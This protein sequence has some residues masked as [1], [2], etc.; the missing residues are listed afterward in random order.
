MPAALVLPAIRNSISVIYPCNQPVTCEVANTDFLLI[1]PVNCFFYSREILKL[2]NQVDTLLQG[3]LD[4]RIFLLSIHEVWGSSDRWNVTPIMDRKAAAYWPQSR[5]IKKYPIWLWNIIA[6]DSFIQLPS[7]FYR[8][9]LK[10][11]T[12]CSRAFVR[13]SI[14]FFNPTIQWIAF[15]NV[16]RVISL[17]KNITT[18]FGVLKFWS[19]ENTENLFGPIFQP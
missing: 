18:G 6:Y 16:D 3:N 1:P 8:T 2:R 19:K 17:F 13:C 4:W 10:K 5:N 12:T 11:H 14:K 9:F 7:A 15:R